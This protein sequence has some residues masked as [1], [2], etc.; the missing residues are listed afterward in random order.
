MLLFAFTAYAKEIRN[1]FGK[2]MRAYQRKLSSAQQL[3]LHA[4]TDSHSHQKVR[5]AVV[6]S[7]CICVCMY[8]SIWS[9]IF[10]AVFGHEFFITV[11][12]CHIFDC[13]EEKRF[14]S[15]FNV[16]LQSSCACICRHINIY[17]YINMYA[18][19]VT[20]AFMLSGN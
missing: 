14:H 18:F 2:R 16:A 15:L 11:G 6:V 5:G 20:T 19:I 10:I 13:E 17:V 3:A 1:L 4:S 12:G 8:L 7:L 9:H